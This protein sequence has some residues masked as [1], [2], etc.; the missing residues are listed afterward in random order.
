MSLQKNQRSLQILAC[1]GL[2]ASLVGGYA[3]AAPEIKKNLPCVVNCANKKADELLNKDKVIAS[4]IDLKKLDKKAISIVVEKSKYR[5]TVYYQK[6]P[7][8]AYAIALGAN[9]KDDKLRQGDKRTPEGKFR[10][11]DLYYHSE[12]SKFIW[13]DYPRLILG[14]NLHRQKREVK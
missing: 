1:L 9:P 3:I 2:V 13:L 10:V 14:V 4:L 11:R 7:I 8:K 5:L 12:W 6:K